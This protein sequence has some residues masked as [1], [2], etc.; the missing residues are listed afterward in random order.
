M[1]GYIK[2]SLCIV[3]ILIMTV[4]F[5]SFPGTNVQAITANVS[6]DLIIIAAKQELVKK[7]SK[8]YVLMSDTEAATRA[9]I[10]DDTIL[11]MMAEGSSIS[12]IDE[13]LKSYK[14]YR[15]DTQQELINSIT[16][17]SSEPADAVCNSVSIYY[18]SSQNQWIVSGGGM[19]NSTT[20]EW[21]WE[22]SSIWWVPYVGEI[23]NAGGRD[24]VG[25][26]Y[27]NVSGTYNASVVSCAG[28]MTDRNGW[29]T[30]SYS[31]SDG[32]GAHGVSF[33]IQDKLKAVLFDPFEQNIANSYRY[34]GR[35]YS[36]L[37]RY[38]SNFINYNGNARVF[39]AHTWESCQ[40]SGV[41]FGWGSGFTFG[42]DIDFSNQD[43]WKIFSNSDTSF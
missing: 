9:K 20:T 31:P 2:R 36:A 32:D 22:N 5:I 19:W 34:L 37:I 12:S 42:I 7:Y 21:Y 15:L 14:V 3:C 25:I 16:P 1:K 28:Y 27:N 6:N 39:Y 43:G 38:N 18:D 35:G 30:T 29:A 23:H 26:T 8:N 4:T 10:I 17:L 41:S 11:K 24:A 13:V 33:E 40:I